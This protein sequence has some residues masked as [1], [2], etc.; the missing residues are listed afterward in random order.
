MVACGNRHSV[1]VSRSEEVSEDDPGVDAMTMDI[2]RMRRVS[3][4][5]EEA[6]I[7][8][9]PFDGRCVGGGGRA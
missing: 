3:L 9:G 1:F 8:P 7:V 2:A 5:A 4:L 6:A